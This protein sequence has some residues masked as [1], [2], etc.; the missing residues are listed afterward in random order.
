MPSTNQGGQQ[1]DRRRFDRLADDVGEDPARWLDWSLVDDADRRR[2]ALDRIASID[3]YAVLAAF[4]A[5]ER[6][7]ADQDDRDPRTRIMKAID[8]REQTLDRIGER[9]DRIPAGP[10]RPCD[11]CQDDDGLT[12]EDLRERDRDELDRRFGSYST[13]SASTEASTTETKET[14]LGAF[15]AGQDDSSDDAVATDGGRDE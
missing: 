8:E 15:A 4:R 5:V 6:A 2:M 7:L 11:C 3:K 12:P 14:S 9:P 10:R 1:R 13:S